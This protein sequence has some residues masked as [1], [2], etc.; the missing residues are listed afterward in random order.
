MLTTNPA[1]NPIVTVG[2][3][4][5]GNE[6]AV[7]AHRRTVRAREP[8]P[9]AGDGV[10]AQGDSPPGSASASSTR[11][12]STRRTAPAPR[13]PAASGLNQ[14][15]RSLLKSAQT[16][17]GAGPHRRARGRAMRARRR[18]R[19]YAA[20]PG[21]P[22]P[23]D[24]PPDRRRR[25]RPRRQRQEGAVPRPLGHAN[26]VAK[27]TGAGNRDVLVTERGAS[28]G[29]NTLVSDIRALPILA[30]RPARR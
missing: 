23:A 5:F 16:L 21:V 24:R 2:K 11:P 25:D 14:R 30:A 7:R 4:R 26:V 17:G 8:C 1:P 15:C 13:A 9:R 19:R 27:V 3:A 12:P 18:G 10:C 22:L 6:P 29:Y 28:F 20:D